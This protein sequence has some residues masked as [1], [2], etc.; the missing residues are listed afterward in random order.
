MFFHQHKK[1]KTIL[2]D[3]FTFVEETGVDFVGINAG[4]YHSGDHGYDKVRSASREYQDLRDR[5][6]DG[7]VNLINACIKIDS[8][9][10]AR[11]LQTDFDL[12]KSIGEFA[13]SIVYN[14]SYNYNLFLNSLERN[15]S[16]SYLH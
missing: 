6:V 7:D 2:S 11:A 4:Q 16:V 1:S 5:N 15:V 9:I 8:E 10:S 3:A 13:N 14:N 12:R